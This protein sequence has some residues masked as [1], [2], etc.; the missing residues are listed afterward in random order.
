MPV[1]PY[2]V[3]SDHPAS[4]VALNPDLTVTVRGRLAVLGPVYVRDNLQ[5]IRAKQNEN[6]GYFAPA[7]VS[8]W[9]YY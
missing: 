1:V 6:S 5:F 2:I 7:S 8:D 4:L 3:L 9:M